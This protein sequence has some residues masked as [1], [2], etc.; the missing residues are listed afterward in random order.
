MWASCEMTY[1]PTRSPRALPC[2]MLMSSWGG[3]FT[4]GL[5]AGEARPINKD[6]ALAGKFS[7]TVGGRR[8]GK[9]SSREHSPLAERY[10]GIRLVVAESFERIYRQNA[11]NIGLY[12]STD[13]GLIER[14]QRGEPIAIEELLAPRDRL[15]AS[16]LRMGG[17]SFMGAST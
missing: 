13:F 6:A 1:R 17:Y 10:A 3:T 12:T 8:Y 16:I 15:A 2:S 14:I 11:D 4:L 9:G 7:I 5:A